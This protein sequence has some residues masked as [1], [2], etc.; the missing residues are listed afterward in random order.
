[1]RAPSYKGLR[2]VPSPD[3]EVLGATAKAAQL[4][5][6]GRELRLANPDKILWPQAGFTSGT[7]W[8]PVNA[9]HNGAIRAMHPE[10]RFCKFVHA[11]DWLFPECLQRMVE[12]ALARPSIGVVGSYRLEDREVLHDGLMP[13]TQTLMPDTDI[14]EYIC[15][16]NEK[17]R[18]H[19][20]SK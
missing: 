13:Y 11:D 3:V 15:T 8:L 5:V 2:D 18:L 16:E 17:D 12:V 9:N 19:L 14:L 6:G 20:T 1:M 4:R 10:S 7:P